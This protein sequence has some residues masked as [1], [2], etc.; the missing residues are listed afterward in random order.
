M[1]LG[2]GIL[3]RTRNTLQYNIQHTM[4]VSVSCPLRLDSSGQWR[5]FNQ[6]EAPSVW[7]GGRGG[8]LLSAATG[9]EGGGGF[10]E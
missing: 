4:L 9:G 10:N 8:D 7:A 5:N 6:S 1:W 3:Q 2:M